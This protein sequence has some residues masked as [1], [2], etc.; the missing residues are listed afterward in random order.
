[1]FVYAS[2][3]YHTPTNTITGNGY[4][5]SEKL[6]DDGWMNTR[7][8]PLRL[9]APATSRRISKR[10]SFASGVDSNAPPSMV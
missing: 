2:P 10:Y 3:V 6:I 9:S 8:S 1:M 7:V 5:R 4:S